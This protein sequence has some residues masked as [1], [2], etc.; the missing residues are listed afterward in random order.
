MTRRVLL[1]AVQHRRTNVHI[2]ART[3]LC[4]MQDHQDVQSNLISQSHDMQ[5]LR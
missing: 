4:V 5:S 1:L 3:R 2:W